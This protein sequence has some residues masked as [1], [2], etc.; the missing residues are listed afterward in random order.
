[1]FVVVAPESTFV[2]ATVLIGVAS[3]VTVWEFALSFTVIWATVI[4]D[5]A[6]LSAFAPF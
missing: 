1:M 5:S 4:D 6:V 2:V 3:L